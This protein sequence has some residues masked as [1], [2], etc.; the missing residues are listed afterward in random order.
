M[1]GEEPVG[2]ATA[3]FV[4]SSVERVQALVSGWVDERYVLACNGSAV[5]L[6]PTERAGEYVGGVRF[7]AWQPPVS[8]LHP[9]I[10]A[11]APLVLDVYDR[12]TGRSLGG[13]THHVSHPGGRHYE[14]FPV[15]ANEAEARRRARFFPFGHT[16]GP[17][18]EPEADAVART[19]AHVGLAPNRLTGQLSVMARDEMVDGKGGL[20]PQWRD[21]LGVL[22]GLGHG[23]LAE[24]ARQLDRV[25]EEEG[26]AG[27]LPGSP[28]A[29]WRFDPIPLPLAQ[30]EFALLEAGLAQRAH[31]LDAVLADLYGAQRLLADGAV[32]TALVYANP[33]FLRPCRHLD[34][35]PAVRSM[36]PIWCA[37]LMA[38]GTYWRI[39]RTLP[40]V[41]RM[42]CRTAGSLV[43][44]CRSFLSRSYR[45]TSIRSSSFAW[46]CC[47][48]S[49]RPA[50]RH[51]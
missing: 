15:N 34:G 47:G 40:T 21:L 49:H 28:P 20:R 29:P 3:R 8:A 50:R 46:T 7:K 10:P 6:T 39:A 23:V 2:G 24:R 31:L 26:V 4:D 22:A 43:V 33:A 45:A 16:P 1:L 44:S 13:L 19:S 25:M 11:Q 42:P 35:P 12:W 37:R 32:P 36:P 30:S 38:H 9:T 27:L 17:M 48:E 14:R 18:A 51:C 41:W 5:P